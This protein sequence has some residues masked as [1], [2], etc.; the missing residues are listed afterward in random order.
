MGTFF[1][2]IALLIGA[3][4]PLILLENGIVRYDQSENATQTFETGVWLLF[5]YTAWVGIFYALGLIPLKWYDLNNKKKAEI[6][7]QL[8]IMRQA[9][10]EV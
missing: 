7:K 5:F 3:T 1:S 6:Q 8:E 2:A 9:K 4:A 10:A